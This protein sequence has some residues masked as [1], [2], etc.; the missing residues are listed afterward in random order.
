MS[1]EQSVGPWRPQVATPASTDS[2]MAQE[3]PGKAHQSMAFAWAAQR[4]LLL[5]C[6]Q[7]VTGCRDSA[8]DVVQ[9]TFLKLWEREDLDWVRD[10]ERFLFRVVRNMAIDWYRACARD[11]QRYVAG[12][13]DLAEQYVQTIT[14]D[15]CVEGA[16]SLHDVVAALRCLPRRMQKVLVMTRLEG[17]TQREVARRLDVSPT[18]VNFML[19]DSLQHCRDSISRPY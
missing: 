7:A 15:D 18:L 9:T 19:R 3:C 16:R 1:T 5:D 4:T 8:E 10:R 6:A 11:K 12:V 17:L 13:D 2:F 14:P